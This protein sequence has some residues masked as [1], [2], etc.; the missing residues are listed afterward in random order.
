MAQTN[1]VT[2]KR[3]ASIEFVDG[4]GFKSRWE[5]EVPAWVEQIVPGDLVACDYN[6]EIKIGTVLTIGA[7][8]EHLNHCLVVCRI[9]IQEHRSNVNAIKQRKAIMTEMAERKAELDSLDEY[10]KLKDDPVMAALLRSFVG[11]GNEE[12]APLTI[13]TE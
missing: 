5:Y 13:E 4:E 7:A 10:M 12:I 6:G 3:I 8:A 2:T 11:D 9:P 1:A